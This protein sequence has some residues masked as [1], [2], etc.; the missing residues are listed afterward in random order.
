MKNINIKQNLKEEFLEQ[1]YYGKFNYLLII[2][3]ESKSS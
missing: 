3:D 2:N 1:Y